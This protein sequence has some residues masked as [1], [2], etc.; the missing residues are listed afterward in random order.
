MPLHVVDHVLGQSLLVLGSLGPGCDVAESLGVLDTLSS[1]TR[2]WRSMPYH[3]CHTLGSCAKSGLAPAPPPLPANIYIYIILIIYNIHGENIPCLARP[4]PHE[5]GLWSAQGCGGAARSK[6][7]SARSCGSAMERG[8]CAHGYV[9]GVRRLCVFCNQPLK[10][11]RLGRGE[12][13]TLQ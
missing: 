13:E 8:G 4:G 12:E 9:Q 5:P 6:R 10:A 3:V 1:M 11:S 2:K 7:A